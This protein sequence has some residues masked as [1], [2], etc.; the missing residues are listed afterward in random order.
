MWTDAT[1]VHHARAGLALPSVWIG[2]ETGPY[3]GPAY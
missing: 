1:R 3:Q 2:V